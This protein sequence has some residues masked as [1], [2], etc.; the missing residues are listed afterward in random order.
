MRKRNILLFHAKNTKLTNVNID[1]NIAANS[2]EVVNIVANK[3][4]S[5]IKDRTTGVQ[6]LKM[7]S[8]KQ[9]PTFLW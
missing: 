2:L 7:E 1:L 4:D 3:S 9:L 8:I 5:N 6:K